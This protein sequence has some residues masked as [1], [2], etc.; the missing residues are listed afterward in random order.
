MIK[1]EWQIIHRSSTSATLCKHW[2]LF[3]I[4]KS[5]ELDGSI[6]KYPDHH[7]PIA[8][9]Q[10]KVAFFLRHSFESGKHA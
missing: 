9:V 3:I 5:H 8:L 2:Y 4:V 6:R 10:A 7:C 1:V